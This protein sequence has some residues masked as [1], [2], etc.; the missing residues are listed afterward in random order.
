MSVVSFPG[1]DLHVNKNMPQIVVLVVMCHNPVNIQVTI[2]REWE[3]LFH[4]TF[5]V[6]RNFSN[7]RDILEVSRIYSCINCENIRHTCVSFVIETLKCFYQ[8]KK[9]KQR[10][11]N[12]VT[13]WIKQPLPSFLSHAA[14]RHTGSKT[15]AGLEP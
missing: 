11:F 4:P 5:Q 7:V 12:Q 10:D 15:L 3:S 2:L 13:L 8:N 1:F 9:L 6:G 14:I